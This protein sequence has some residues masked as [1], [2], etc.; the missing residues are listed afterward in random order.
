VAWIDVGAPSA[1]RV[2]RASKA[3]Q[4]VEIY[5]ASNLAYLRS[6]AAA[7]RIHRAH[8]IDVWTFAASFL[9]AVE[10]RFERNLSFTL[11]RTE[12]ELYVTIAGATLEGEVAHSK[13]SD[14]TSGGRAG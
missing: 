7:G 3:A 4:T 1:A 12:G 5:G 6:E 10:A 2:H 8:D 14:E 13:L 9:D 11:V